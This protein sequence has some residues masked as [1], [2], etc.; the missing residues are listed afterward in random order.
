MLCEIFMHCTW[1]YCD[2]GS[3]KN[4]ICSESIR[5]IYMTIDLCSKVRVEKNVEGKKQNLERENWTR[6]QRFSV[7]SPH[8][9]TCNH[10][11]TLQI[12]NWDS[13]WLSHS[14]DI[15][16]SDKSNWQ[17]SK[18]EKGLGAD[19]LLD[20]SGVLWVNMCR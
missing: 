2:V 19:P 7:S 11:P 3:N 18:H 14:L 17:D 12:L 6:N 1:W 13:L 16:Y 10:N 20:V 8:C 15:H 9:A 5:I 4:A